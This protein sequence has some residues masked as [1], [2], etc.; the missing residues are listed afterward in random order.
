MALSALIDKTGLTPADHGLGAI[1]GL[2]RGVLFVLL[3][4]TL[5]G[6]TPLPA[7]SWWKNAMF[8][9]VVVGVVEQIKTRLPEPVRDWLPSYPSY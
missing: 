4:V 8:S 2:A 5:A 9:K 1:F 7:E 3:L 6:F